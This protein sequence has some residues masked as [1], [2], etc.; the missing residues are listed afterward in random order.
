MLPGGA[1][2]RA[3]YVGSAGSRLTVPTWQKP[4]LSAVLIILPP[5]PPAWVFHPHRD[6]FS[7]VAR[8]RSARNSLPSPPISPCLCRVNDRQ[9]NELGSLSPLIVDPLCLQHVS[10]LCCAMA[11]MGATPLPIGSWWLTISVTYSSLKYL[12]GWQKSGGLPIVLCLDLWYYRFIQFQPSLDADV[13]PTPDRRVIRAG[14]RLFCVERR[15]L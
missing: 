10:L 15:G 5:Q 9:G 12:G 14:D 7:I 6:V 11:G 2:L 4:V 8:Q 3:V 13:Q 1:G